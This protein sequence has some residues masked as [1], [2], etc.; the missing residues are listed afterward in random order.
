MSIFIE[1]ATDTR[2]DA[3]ALA[4]TDSHTD[5]AAATSINAANPERRANR[6][7]LAA[8]RPACL[9]INNRIHLGMIRNMSDMGV[10]VQ[11][12]QP[13][14]KGDRVAYFWDEAKIVRARVAWSDGNRHG[15]DNDDQARVFD[16]SFSYRSVRI[17]CSMHA[18]VWA[19]GNCHVVRVINL[20]MGGMRIEGLELRPGTL[21][22][23]EVGGLEIYNASTKWADGR[24]A[25]IHFSK[26]L[27]Q[28]ELARLMLD[29][30]DHFDEPVAA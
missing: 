2:P 6:R 26:R 27:T 15:L 17:P 9:I 29:H 11:C 1:R 25:G 18:K 10:M 4:P 19:A 16:P 24:V 7:F 22:T 12:D 23:I 21:L 30:P 20:S 5:A 13:L 8:F 28:C 3:S 14:K